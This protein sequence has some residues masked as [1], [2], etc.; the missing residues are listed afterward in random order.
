[1]FVRIGADLFE[2]TEIAAVCHGPSSWQTTIVLRSGHECVVGQEFEDAL[3]DLTAAGL[4]EDPQSAVLP[5][6]EPDEREELSHLAGLGFRWIARDADGKAYA[7]RGLPTF[8]GAYWN[9][10]LAGDSTVRLSG[11]Y[12]FVDADA[13]KPWSIEDLL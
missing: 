11:A 3:D 6:L 9:S 13:L 7:Y 1:M 4:L 8:D 5:S 2:A 12:D 10:D